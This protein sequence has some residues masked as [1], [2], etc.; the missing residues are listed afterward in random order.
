MFSEKIQYKFKEVFERDFFSTSQGGEEI[1][2]KEDTESGKMELRLSLT[3]PAIIIEDFDKKPKCKFLLQKK[4]YYNKC[5]DYA[6]FELL[7][8]EKELF[9]LH[10]FELT[11]TVGVS[12]W[13]DKIKPQGKSAYVHCLAIA[14]CL[15]ITVIETEFYT[16]YENDEFHKFIESEDYSKNPA[17]LKAGFEPKRLSPKY[18]WEKGIN[19][20][21]FGYFKKFKHNKIQLQLNDGTYPTGDYS[22]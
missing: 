1:I 7:D 3:N 14:A 4:G 8:K 16:I 12:K 22:L 15:E 6:I 17:L 11:K 19:K 9:K 5:A 21:N 13:K 18:E 20:L 2:L 10:I